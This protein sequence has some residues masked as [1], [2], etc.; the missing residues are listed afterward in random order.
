MQVFPRWHRLPSHTRT[1]SRK[2]LVR[3]AV[4]I[5]TD[6]I[7]WSRHSEPGETPGTQKCSTFPLMHWVSPVFRQ[8]PDSGSG[9][10]P[11]H[12]PHRSVRHNHRPPRR[13]CYRNGRENLFGRQAS[14]IAPSTQK[15]RPFLCRFPLRRKSPQSGNPHRS[16]HRNRCRFHCKPHLAAA[17]TGEMHVSITV[18][19]THWVSPDATQVPVEHEV[20]VLTKSS[21]TSPS[22][23]SSIPSQV[24]SSV[25]PRGTT[26]DTFLPVYTCCGELPIPH[27]PTP[28][29]PVPG[30]K[31]SSIWP[32]QSSSSPL[33]LVSGA[34]DG[35]HRY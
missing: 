7:V 20:G 33:Q 34:V 15:A 17:G 18:P 29:V 21:S 24:A 1:S 27:P 13:R 22:Q 26:H 2:V 23:S 31:S 35:S 12:N 19:A 28:H 6:S 4:A 8:N 32:S 11:A 5:V 14:R 16:P 10:A 3:N 9:S 25:N 30:M